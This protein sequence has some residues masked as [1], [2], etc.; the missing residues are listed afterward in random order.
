ME[1]YVAA[2][3]I[4]D[5]QNGFH[6]AETWLHSIWE[7]KLATQQP[8][9]THVMDANAKL[10]LSQRLMGRGI[11]LE[12]REEAPRTVLNNEGKVWF[13]IGAFL[14]GWGFDDVRLGGGKG[15][16]KQEAGQIAAADASSRAVTAQIERIKKNFDMKTSEKKEIAENEGLGEDAARFGICKAESNGRD[17]RTIKNVKRATTSGREK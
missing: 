8:A 16:S 13:H 17:I 1:A 10:S 2:V 4:S 14:T 5:P 7:N 3:I 15:L 12:Y 11:K 6:N 9:D